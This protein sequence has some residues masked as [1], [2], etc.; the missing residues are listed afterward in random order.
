MKHLFDYLFKTYKINEQNKEEYMFIANKL[1]KEKK[2]N[3]LHVF[4][5]R[6]RRCNNFWSIIIFINILKK[7]DNATDIKEAILCYNAYTVNLFDFVIAENDTDLIQNSLLQLKNYPDWMYSKKRINVFLRTFVESY[8]HALK[9][10]LI[11]EVTYILRHTTHKSIFELIC[12]DISIYGITV[13]KVTNRNI[14]FDFIVKYNDYYR[15]VKY[16]RITKLL[17]HIDNTL[18]KSQNKYILKNIIGMDNNTIKTYMN[19]SPGIY[20]NIF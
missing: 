7:M 3:D 5:R 20:R 11:K 16:E 13:D 12:E 15:K 8:Q 1:I 6:L 4:I 10:E 2:I 19:L 17:K 9:F 18:L 14:L